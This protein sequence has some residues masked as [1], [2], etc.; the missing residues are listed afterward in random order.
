MLCFISEPSL[1]PD[2]SMHSVD[3][4]PE[5]VISSHLF[6]KESSIYNFFL[7]I[8]TVAESSQLYPLLVRSLHRI[9]QLI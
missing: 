8:I 3:D 1:G 5:H 7:P 2:L 4:G 6:K 9:F